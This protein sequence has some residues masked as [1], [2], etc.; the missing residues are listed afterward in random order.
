MTTEKKT[1]ED[2]IRDVLGIKPGAV[3]TTPTDYNETKMCMKAYS[4]Q[5]LAEYKAR[6]K[7][8]IKTGEDWTI[9]ELVNII[10]S[11]T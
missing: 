1:A 6:L 10:D 11:I 7:E 8:L 4:D 9:E 2:V 5:Q 3:S